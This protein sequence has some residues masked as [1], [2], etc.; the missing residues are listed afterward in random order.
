LTDLRTRIFLRGAGPVAL[1]L[2]G[3]G[4]DAMSAPIPAGICRAG[5]VT[6]LHCARRG[7]VWGKRAR[8]EAPYLGPSGLGFTV[9]FA[10]V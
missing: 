2:A 1:R 4:G 6:P 3:G 5:N 8:E 9:Y 7:R 10:R